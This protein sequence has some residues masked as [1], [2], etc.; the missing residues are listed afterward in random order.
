MKYMH[1]LRFNLGI[2]HGGWGSEGELGTGTTTV[3]HE[4]NDNGFPIVSW[5]RDACRGGLGAD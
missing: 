2:W 3:A 1:G 5:E 4:Q